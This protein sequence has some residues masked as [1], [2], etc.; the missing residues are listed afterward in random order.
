MSQFVRDLFQIHEVQ[1]AAWNEFEANIYILSDKIP[2]VRMGIQG[3]DWA[4]HFQ[5]RFRQHSTD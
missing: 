2:P 4:M 5:T 3:A 1:Q